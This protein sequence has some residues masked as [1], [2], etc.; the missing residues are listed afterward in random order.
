MIIN[1]VMRK[2]SCLIFAVL[3]SQSLIRCG[4]ITYPA[5]NELEVRWKVISNNY[6]EQPQVKACFTI[7]NNSSQ[8]LKSGSWALFYNQTPREIVKQPDLAFITR[9]SGDWYKLTPDEGLVLKPG[10][11]VEVVYEAQ[12]WWIKE[13][14]APL[15]LYFVF[16]GKDGS[17]Q[18]IAAAGNYTIEP[19]EKPEQIN[20]HRNDQVPVPTPALAFESNQSM[21]DVPVEQLP[22]IIP[23]P[24]SVKK[25]GTT[26][27]FD[28]V[29][30]ILFQ[31]G[32]ENEANY[33]ASF[34]GKLAGTTITPS[35]GSASRPNSIFLELR[36]VSVNNTTKEAYR[37]EVRSD[38]SIVVTGS[39]AAGV[40][41][42]LQS[43]K[44]L[45]PVS[46]FYSGQ[47]APILPVVVI[48]DAP[49]FE[50]RSLHVDIARNFQTKQTVMKMLDLMS[51]YKLNHMMIILSED[52]AW[53]IEI[54]K[55]PELT[56]VASR[57]GHTLKE[58][59]DILHPSYGSGPFPDSPDSYGSG[60]YTR[61]DYIEILRYAHQR[62]IKVIPTI[63]LPGHSRAAIR[64][65]E[66]RYARY[67]GEGNLA[68]A[69]EFRLID[70]E[71][72]SVYS[73]AQAYDD[74][75][76][77][78]ALESVYTF[79]ETVID[80]IIGMYTEAK[81]PLEYFHTGGD[82]VPEG[83][84]AG[85]PLCREFLASLPE[86]TD[87][88]NLQ[89]IFFKRTVEILKSRGLK[90]GGWEEVA[91]LKTENGDYVPNPDFAGGSVIPWAWNNLGQ[92][93]DLSYRL[94]NAGYPIVMC[95]V[96][97]LYFDLAYS[98]DPKEPGLYWGGFVDA[99][100]AWQFAPYNSFITN[101][102]TGMGRKI[103]PEVEFAGLERLKPGSEKNIVGLQAQ[104]WA[105]TIKGPQMLEYYTLPKLIGFAET[106]WA[107]ERRWESQSNAEIRQKQ[108]DEGWNIFANQLAKRELPRLSGLSGGFNYRIP[109]PGAVVEDGLL[110]ANVEYPGL[111]IRYTTDGS[112][113]GVTSPVYTSPVTVPG[114][115]LLRAFDLSG[116]A[117]REVS[118]E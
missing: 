10:E 110:K 15:G 118:A 111:I 98:K 16:Y 54:E 47:S 99:R 57:R 11:S 2:I 106:A 113:P 116:K 1:D 114:K 53:R 64:A 103:N 37:L 44:A 9:I 52:E 12:A 78:V 49:R 76:V 58:S 85:S 20:R 104:L 14:D 97:N 30:E 105:E 80:E 90:A 109:P 27:N 25:T 18:H 45:L 77:C 19:F 69:E 51:F 62:H 33:I 100:S 91:L 65:M 61:E 92:W 87:P 84:W 71:D 38:K 41:Y 115:V 21:S 101:L 60:Y 94:V 74:N 24:V 107:R 7:V 55:L 79:Y 17:E 112:E 39:D 108:M 36:S 40:F 5:G 8:V 42:G 67:A 43:L 96:S 28:T 59:A 31:E 13:V 102:R 4:K 35:R 117:S 32:L 81:V 6:S 46:V 48:E 3:L 29:P 82:E 95:D 70:P 75:I 22:L 73:S 72:Q 34:V 89:A 88:R 26:V 50:L 68:A 23:S 56:S 63:N 66:A 86:I 83:A 93:A